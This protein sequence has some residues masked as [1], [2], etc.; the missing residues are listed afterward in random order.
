MRAILKIIAFMSLTSLYAQKFT[1]SGFVKDSASG[2]TLINASIVNKNFMGACTNAQGFYS[3]TL[4]ADTVALSYSY[5]GYKK[6]NIQLYLAKDTVLNI[7]L[8]TQTLGEIV[9]VDDNVSS[10]HETTSMSA[11]TLPVTQINSLPALLGEADVLKV[12][13]LVPG[14]HAGAEGSSGVYVRGGGADQNLILLDGVAVYNASH[15]FGFFSIFNTDAINHVELTKGGFPARYG[16]RLSSVVDIR[17]KNGNMK[18]IEGAGSIGIISSKIKLE[19]PIA[20]ERASFI[21]S[22]RRTYIDIVAQPFIKKQAKGDR[23]GYYFYDLNLKVNYILNQ[24]NRIFFS[25]YFGSDKAYAKDKVS[26]IGDTVQFRSNN[27]SGLSWGNLINSLRWHHTFSDNLFLNFTATTS[28][29]NFNVSRDYYESVAIAGAGQEVLSFGNRYNSGI[30]DLA[31]KL[32]IEYNANPQHFIR[33]GANHILHKF[34][35]GVYVYKSNVD[36]GI[37]SGAQIVR[38]AESSIYIEDEFRLNEKTG[39]NLGVHTSAFFVQNKSYYSFQPRVSSRI[40]ITKDLSWKTSYS[41]MTQYIHLLTNVGIGLPTDLWVPSTERIRPQ[42]ATQIATGLSKTYRSLY[43]VTVEAYLKNMSHLIEY[44]DG[45]S[46]LNIEGDW[47]DK[48]AYGGKGKSYGLELLI[49]RKTGKTTGWAGYT[50]SKTTRQFSALNFG[51]KFPYKYDRRHDINI[52]VTHRLKKQINLSLVWVYGSG[53]YLTLPSASYEA[54]DNSFDS[55]YPKVGKGL[56]YGDRNSYQTKSYHRL[57]VSVSCIKK[58]KWGERTWTFAIYNVYNRLNPFFIDIGSDK[59]N[60]PRFIE[61]TLFP[62]MPSLA[63]SF[64]F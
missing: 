2:E 35:P 14:V 19:G 20:S 42:E 37:T 4:R 54:I 62:V 34:S 32:D 43:E 11:F 1:I 64:K 33:A 57:D 61:Y 18:K 50:L 26:Y 16:G 21:V 53:N 60:N 49:Q 47:Q 29:Y 45:A 17:M 63:Y 58:K 55:R 59:N 31:I 30:R 28:R 39:L 27:M 10:I 8:A 51:R 22:A 41:R 6:Q 24:H 40:S 5:V 13:Q 38:P 23:K 9:I 12:L 25:T 52:A 3:L 56:Y 44:K 15:L 36:T 48:V 46:Y 7:N